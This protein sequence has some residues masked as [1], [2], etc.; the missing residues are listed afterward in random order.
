MSD[1]DKAPQ[2]DKPRLVLVVPQTLKDRIDTATG[3]SGEYSSQ[4]ELTRTAIRHELDADDEGTAQVEAQASLGE[5]AAATLDRI[6][7]AIGEANDRLERL[8]SETRGSGPVYDLQ[9]ALY[10]YVLP[11]QEED[12]KYAEWAI[13]SE[14]IART[15]DADQDDVEDA[16]DRLSDMT[17]DVKSV[18][19]GPEN[20]EYW[21][22][23][24]GSGPA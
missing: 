20:K 21:F 4:A 16:L 15:L 12:G 9:K 22:R 6:E 10:N 19:G 3:D 11:M 18:F 1:D 23:K 14:E 2:S 17:G 7:S 8:E 5:E 24:T 13:T